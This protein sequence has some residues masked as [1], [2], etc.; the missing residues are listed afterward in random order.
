MNWIRY[1][2]E[3]K[4]NFV[5]AI[6]DIL[7]EFEIY[8]FE[9]KDNELQP[10]EMLDGKYIDIP[11]ILSDDDTATVSFYFEEENE[12]L[13]TKLR[14]RFAN[15]HIIFEIKI[16]RTKEEDYIN[17]WKKYWHTLKI[18]DLYIKPSWEEVTGEMEKGKILT[19]DPKTAFGTGSHETTHL[20]IEL[21]IKY[22][23]KEDRVLDVGTGSGILALVSILYGASIS[24][25]IDL[26]ENAIIAS[27]ENALINNLSDKTKF[28]NGNIISDESFQEKCG[29]NSYNIVCANILP[30]V[31]VPLSK[32]IDKMMCKDGL[33]IY[34]GILD[35]KVDEIVEAINKNSNLEYVETK[36]LNGWNA[37]VARKIG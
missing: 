35:F 24:L 34:S 22:L 17:N 28:L 9:I 19:L 5:D 36:S 15:R 10:R 8:S 29:L 30:D 12:D 37:I 4:T 20:V 6:C 13:V 32:M 18:Q 21:L 27:K 26:D 31:L 25:G 16:S 7:N 11:P 2:V 1:D 3:T 14:K 33:I 23:K